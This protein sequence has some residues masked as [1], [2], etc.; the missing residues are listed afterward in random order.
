MVPFRPRG[1]KGAPQRS[2]EGPQRGAGGEMNSNELIVI[3]YSK[4]CDCPAA[5]VG[6]ASPLTSQMAAGS[7]HRADSSGPVRL[8]TSMTFAGHSESR[9]HR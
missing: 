2:D 4:S 3:S 8:G 7:S 1:T 5:K 9:E 6:P